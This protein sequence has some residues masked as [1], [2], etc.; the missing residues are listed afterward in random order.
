MKTLYMTFLLAL[1]ALEFA[2]T[3]FAQVPN[4]NDTSDGNDNTGSG[5]GALGGPKASNA[6]FS[7]TA[8]GYQALYSNMTGDQN[9][10]SGKQALFSNTNGGV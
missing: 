1:G 4:A 7:N 10:G 2:G 3:A 8:S 5:L 6:G 9:T